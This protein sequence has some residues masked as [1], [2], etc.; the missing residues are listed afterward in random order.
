M[1]AL[2]HEPVTSLFI[3]TGQIILP[4]L[5]TYRRVLD[6]HRHIFDC[7]KAKDA[8]KARTWMHKHMD[9]FRRAYELTELS[10][11]TP[12]DAVSLGISQSTA[13]R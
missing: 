5:K 4:R 9:D 12:L 11:D 3:P 13:S 2:A 8:A 6:A 1:L 7:L 10:L